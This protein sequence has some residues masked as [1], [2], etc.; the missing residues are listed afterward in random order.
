MCRQE[1]TKTENLLAELKVPLLIITLSVNINQYKGSINPPENKGAIC[2]L[3]FQF[4]R[5]K[6]TTNTLHFY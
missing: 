5:V 3:L 6:Q 1:S 4:A 2:L